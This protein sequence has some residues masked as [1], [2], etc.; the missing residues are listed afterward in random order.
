M[1]KFLGAM[2][3]TGACFAFAQNIVQ[4]KRKQ[5]SAIKEL[6]TF[7]TDLAREITFCLEPL[8]QLVKRL[9]QEESAIT[10]SFVRE[11]NQNTKQDMH[12]PFRDIWQETLSHYAQEINLP[13][14]VTSLMSALG[15]HLGEADFETE[16][17][18]LQEAVENLYNLHSS[19]EKDNVKTEK[20][21]RSLGILSGVFIV[22]LL[23]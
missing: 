6:Y 9:A 13:K 4:A 19:L 2:L 23:L 3:V 10:P 21:A 20:L 8:P 17:N 1:L 12:R 15:E 7:L 16:T 11:L 18:R 22:I 14:S 5:L